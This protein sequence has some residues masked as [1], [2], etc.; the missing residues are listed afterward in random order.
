MHDLDVVG[1]SVHTYSAAQ[2]DAS[3]HLSRFCGFR[4]FGLDLLLG[5]WN[6]DA[7]GAVLSFAGFRVFREC[8]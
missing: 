8:G 2:H 1:T 7:I 5:H 6:N 4:E 3:I